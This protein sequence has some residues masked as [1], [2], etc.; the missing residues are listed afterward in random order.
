MKADPSTIHM[1]KMQGKI[2]AL[3]AR[4]KQRDDTDTRKS[5]VDEACD[6]LKD[7]AM[8]ADLR[9]KLLKFH[10]D[11]GPA[12]F[13]AYVDETVA[14]FGAMTGNTTGDT[15]QFTA[16]DPKSPA[17]VLK[18]Y[19]QGPDEGERAARF[20]ANWQ[21]LRDHGLHLGSSQERYVETNMN[22]AQA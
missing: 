11:H 12:A 4:D 19:K 17:V 20:A 1:A 16:N 18:F 2:D 6:R 15:V 5:D 3:E 14:T 7:R 10:S 13:K 22:L 21:E 9:G 8:G